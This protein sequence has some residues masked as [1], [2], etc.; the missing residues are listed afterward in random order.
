MGITQPETRNRWLDWQPEAQI[1]LKTAESTPT[2]PTERSFDGFVGA[3][4]AKSPGICAEPER[5]FDGSTYPGFPEIHGT[6]WAEWKA[7]A[8]NRL[9]EDYGVIGQPGRIMAKTVQDGLDH[10]P[11]RE[12][13][14]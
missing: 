12:K 3:T 1:L 5:G 4:P 7:D 9:F 11:R 2:K 13:R 8:L 6:P 14:Y 10:P